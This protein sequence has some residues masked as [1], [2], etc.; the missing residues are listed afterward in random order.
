M[1]EDAGKGFGSVMFDALTM[2][3][4]AKQEIDGHEKICAER[5]DNINKQIA[6]IKS[7]M[8]AQFAE[9]KSDVAAKFG[10]V[11]KILAWAGVTMLAII[12]GALSWSLQQQWAAQKSENERAAMQISLLRSQLTAIR[13]MPV[14]PVSPNATLPGATAPV[15]QEEP[16]DAGR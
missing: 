10:E 15:V 7:G 12:V 16:T 3:R 2:A 6:E 8:A 14:I 13:G 1:A 9:V 11:K 5:Y 4:E